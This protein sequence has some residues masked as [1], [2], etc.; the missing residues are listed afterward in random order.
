MPNNG[1][2]KFMNMDDVFRIMEKQAEGMRFD[3]E[4]S[5]L[6]TMPQVGLSPKVQGILRQQAGNLKNSRLGL[7]SM[8]LPKIGEL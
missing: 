3:Q 8:G 7:K 2:Y 1:T 4:M 5:A 6:G